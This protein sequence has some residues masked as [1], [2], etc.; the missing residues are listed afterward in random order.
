[1][2]P[3]YE[4]KDI[5]SLW[6]EDQ[7]FTY[8]FQVEMALLEALE[9]SKMIPKVAA[10]FNK[11]KINLPRIHEIEATVHHDVIAFCFAYL[12]YPSGDR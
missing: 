8:F 2:I 1:M 12:E 11:A 9:E 10:N 6:T 4:V 5:S 3:R 7:K